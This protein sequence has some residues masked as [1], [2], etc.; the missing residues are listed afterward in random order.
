M[1][2]PKIYRERELKHPKETPRP[3]IL[4]QLVFPR[5]PDGRRIDNARGEGIVGCEIGKSGGEVFP[6]KHV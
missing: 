5:K 3:S 6:E 4:V 1:Q 2:R